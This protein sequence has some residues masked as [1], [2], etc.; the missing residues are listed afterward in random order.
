MNAGN[1]KVVSE[2]SVTLHQYKSLI[3]SYYI[4]DAYRHLKIFVTFSKFQPL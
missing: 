1:I 2:G 4:S 3:F